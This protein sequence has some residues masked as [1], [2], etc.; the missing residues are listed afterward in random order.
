MSPHDEKDFPSNLSIITSNFGIFNG[1]LSF[2]NGTFKFKLI[3]YGSIE[4]SVQ[5]SIIHRFS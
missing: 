4:I 5:F 3:I 2:L 1:T